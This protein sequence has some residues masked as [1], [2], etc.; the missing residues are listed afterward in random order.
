MKKMI[1]ENIKVII[2]ALALIVAALAGSYSGSFV[3]SVPVPVDNVLGA[4][5]SADINSEYLSVNG[6]TTF[7]RT[8]GLNSASTTLCS[9][10]TP[11]ATT[12]LTYASIQATTGTSSTLYLDIAKHASNPTATTTVLR[13]TQTLTGN[14]TVVASS[15]PNGNGADPVFAPQQYLN[16]IYTSVGNSLTANT[17]VGKCYAE[18]K[19]N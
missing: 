17:L 2:G 4:F 16:F 3:A 10:R 7:Y 18:F 13:G 6:V 14:F 5:P 9:F 19:Q 11:N 8:S 12:T 15:S 1:L